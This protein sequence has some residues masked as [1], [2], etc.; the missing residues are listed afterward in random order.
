MSW[1]KLPIWIGLIWCTGFNTAFASKILILGDSLTAADGV[2]PKNSWV[3]LIDQRLKQ[4]YGERYQLVNAG[5]SGN[6]THNGLVRLPDLLEQHKPSFVVLSLGSN[7]GLRGLPLAR[8]RENLGSMIS[9]SIAKQAQVM[10]IAAVLPTNYGSKYRTQ[11]NQVFEDLAQEAEL[12]LVPALLESIG[13]RSDLMQADGLHPTDA[14]QTIIAQNIWPH[15]VKFLGSNM[16][17]AEI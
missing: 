13:G 1:W 6:T 2:N 17:K 9:L 4:A 14:A 16:Q 12:T 3:S 15:F 11:F 10:L 8:L 7:D 5:T